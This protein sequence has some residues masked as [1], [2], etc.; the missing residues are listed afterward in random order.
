MFL[1]TIV[2][3]TIAFKPSAAKA[4]E[5][6]FEIAAKLENYLNI[7]PDRENKFEELW[8]AHNDVSNLSP[9]QL[10]YKDVKVL[11]DVVIPGLPMLVEK[12]LQYPY[13]HEALKSYC[14]E[15][16]CS[17]LL[18]MGLEAGNGDVRRDIAFF[19]NACR[20]NV[21]TMIIDALKDDKNLLL[22]EIE[23]GVPALRYFRQNNSKP[24][25]KYI[26]PVVKDVISKSDAL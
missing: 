25:R 2:F 19:T 15:K 1:E 18:L 24:S 17:S 22:E 5:L 8:K 16:S 20:N 12:Y 13:V 26:I 11:K 7:K 14:E 4:K 6:D 23:I 3:D 21:L 9:K 10:L